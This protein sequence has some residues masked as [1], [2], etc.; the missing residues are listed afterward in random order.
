MT[1]VTVTRDQLG[2]YIATN[3]AGAQLHFGEGEDDFSPVELLLVALAGCTGMDVDYLTS[4]RAEPDEFVIVADAESVKD[5]VDGNVLA[6]LTVTFRLRFPEG[7]DGDRAR[8]ALP[9]AIQRSH[10]RLCTVGRTIERPTAIGT[11]IE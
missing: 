7:S 1:S 4:R 8:I 9:A 2:S 6:D 10:D 11:H 5:A 3:L